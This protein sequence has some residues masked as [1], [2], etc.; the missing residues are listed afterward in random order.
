[1]AT[2]TEHEFPLATE[3]H[4]EDGGGANHGVDSEAGASGSSPGAVNLSEDAII[5][6]IVVVSV[7]A[8]LG[9]G[10]AVLFYVAKKREWKIRENIRKSARKVVIAM[11]PRRSEFPKELKDSMPKSKRGHRKL[12]DDVPPTP[13][14]GPEDLEKGI[15]AEVRGKKTKKWGRT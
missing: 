2:A 9:I 8:V 15:P 6:I 11:T 3:N 14:L 10:M 7:F 1:M 12:S 5:A 4:F 13:R